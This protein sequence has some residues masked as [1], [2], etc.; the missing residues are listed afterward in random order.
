MRFHRDDDRVLHWNLKNVLYERHI[1]RPQDFRTMLREHGLQMSYA[2]CYAL[3]HGRPSKV[4]MVVIETV[5][6]MLECSADSLFV[7]GGPHDGSFVRK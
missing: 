7:L 3:F 2:A 6:K 5:M 1:W 4:S